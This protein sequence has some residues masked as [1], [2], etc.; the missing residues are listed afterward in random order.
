MVFVVGPAVSGMM[1]V[2]AEIGGD[3]G[4]LTRAELPLVYNS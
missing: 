4:F 2:R 1:M 3:R